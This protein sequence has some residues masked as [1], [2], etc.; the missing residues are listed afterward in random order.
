MW[1]HQLPVVRN[2]YSAHGVRVLRSDGR[3]DAHLSL[4]RS[5]FPSAVE[6]DFLHRRW[7]VDCGMGA[8]SYASKNKGGLTLRFSEQHGS[9]CFMLAFLICLAASSDLPL[10][11]FLRFPA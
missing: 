1:C 8:C 11:V 7:A 9:N 4:V 2:N 10:G 6:V 5:A 3:L